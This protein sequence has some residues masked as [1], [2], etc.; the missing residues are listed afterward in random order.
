[1]KRSDLFIRLMTGVIFLAVACY[2]G[3]LLYDAIANPYE[4]IIAG[5]YTIE[6]TLPA[7]GYIV[8]TET[9]LSDFGS[10]VLPIVSEG[11]KVA[12]GQA[13]AV[14]YYSTEAL[15]IAGEIRTLTMNIAQL[16]ASSGVDETAG[17]SAMVALSAA[18]NTKDL[19]RLDELSLNIKSA[20]FNVHSDIDTLRSRLAELRGKHIDARTVYAPVSGNF[21]HV[22]D[23]FE[24]ISPNII[25]DMLPTELDAHFKAPNKDSGA[26]KLI[27]EFK[28]YYLAVMDFSDAVRLNVG[29]NKNVHFFG[30]YQAQVSMLVENVGRRE[31][32]ACVVTFSSDR[33]IHDVA[34]LRS[35][36]AE[37]VHDVITGIR[38]PKEAVHLDDRGDGVVEHIFLQT[39]G[40]AERVDI[41]RLPAGNPI[42]IGDS[43]LV[44]DGAETGSSLRVGSVIIVKAKNLKHG[45]VV[46]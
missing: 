19:R 27:T 17:R 44:R 46:G 38:V 37:V 20:I 23:G 26:G 11:E 43:Y 31:G 29:E 15:E 6:E 35:L 12:S 41:E 9:V 42:E 22:V 28:W 25:R 34:S 4:T 21:S 5:S 16:E 33:G 13:V 36:R 24:H 30:A 32:D 2:G 8:R 40:Y 7:E 18:V 1:M 10:S 3:I 14:E 45:A 39:S